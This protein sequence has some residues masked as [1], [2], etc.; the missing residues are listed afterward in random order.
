[1]S[2][3]GVS[4]ERSMINGLSKATLVIGLLTCS[5]P[6]FSQ[7]TSPGMTFDCDVPA[8]RYSSVTQDLIGVPTIRGSVRAME[9]RSGNYLPVAGARIVSS[10]GKQSVGFRLIAA[11]P[12]AERFDVAFE[13]RSGGVSNP[14]T[15]AQVAAKSDIQFSLSLSDAGKATL[16]LDGMDFEV[17]FEPLQ[18]ASGM[19]FCSTAQFKFSDLVFSPD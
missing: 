14:R 18:S 3:A 11:S 7:T 5:A 12:R 19:A 8:D 17:E 4:A 9:L 16:V 1:M 13:T 2:I 6:A 10:D 15:V